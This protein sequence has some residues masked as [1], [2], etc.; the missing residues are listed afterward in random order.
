MY[1][2]RD[3]TR[4]LFAALVWGAFGSILV[5][6]LTGWT[7]IWTLPALITTPLAFPMVRTIYRETSGPPLIS[8]LKA[9]ARL[10]LVVG[11]LLAAG[12]MIG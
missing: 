6:A 5:F 11:V 1:L 12:A 4:A 8:A 9:V 10:H 2:G 3:R 7:P